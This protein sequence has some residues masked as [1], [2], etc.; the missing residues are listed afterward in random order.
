MGVAPE[1]TAFFCKFSFLHDRS[2]NWRGI[3]LAPGG[4]LWQKCSVQTLG[5]EKS[6]QKGMLPAE[7]CGRNTV[8]RHRDMK[9]ASRRGCLRLESVAEAQY[10]GSGT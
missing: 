8:I 3:E 1:L 4:N 10:S 7:I 2:R 5:H 6:K 9:K